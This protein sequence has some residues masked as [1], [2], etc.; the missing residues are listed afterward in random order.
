[1]LFGIRP[2]REYIISLN[3][4]EG[5]GVEPHGK[6]K[7]VLDTSHTPLT[8]VSTPTDTP[9]KQG[10]CQAKNITHPLKLCLFSLFI[11]VKYLEGGHLG[12]CINPLA[13]K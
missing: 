12:G 6:I 9:K 4:R 13:T 2:K 5:G 11:N 1:M 8:R 10:G 3:Q 7:G